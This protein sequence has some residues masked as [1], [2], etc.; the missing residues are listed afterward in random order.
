[1]ASTSTS[2]AFSL[3]DFIAALNTASSAPSSSRSQD[4]TS[5]LR[6]LLLLP[7]S[8]LPAELLRQACQEYLDLTV[9]SELNASGGGLV[10]GRTT[11]TSFD[12]TIKQFG[13]GSS[14]GGS[15]GDEV[16]N[17]GSA[18][19]D[20]E[21]A[22]PAIRDEETQKDVLEMALEKVQPRVLSF[23]DQVSLSSLAY[24]LTPPDNS[25]GR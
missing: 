7:R 10:V 17:E 23:E 9:F 13:S 16:M 24:R 8:A 18:V 4:Y 15:G 21:E 6:S 11:L 2:S 20:S 12:E 1:M 3:Q 5:H 22:L 25:D 14:K 19:G